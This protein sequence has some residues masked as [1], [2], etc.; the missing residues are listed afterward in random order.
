MALDFTNNSLTITKNGAS[1]A[2]FT[3]CNFTSYD[4]VLPQWGTATNGISGSSILL[5]AGQRAFEYTVPTDHQSLCTANLPA[6]DIADPSQYFD[7]VLDTGANILSSA[8]S[9]FSSGL[10]WIKDRD[11]SNQNQFVDSVRGNQAW[12]APSDVAQSTYSAPSGNSV[13]WCWSA[14]D[15]WSN[16]AGSNGADTASSGYRNLAR[17]FSIARFS[18]KRP[19]QSVFAH[20]LNTKPEFILTRDM[21]NE[22]GCVAYHVH[23]GTYYVEYFDGYFGG[24]SSGDYRNVTSSIIDMGNTSTGNEVGT[25]NMMCYSWAPI[26]GYS[27]F[28]SYT[29]N[30]SSDGAF[31]HTGFRVGWVVIK[32]RNTSGGVFGYDWNVIDVRRDTYNPSWQAL[33]SNQTYSEGSG[34]SSSKAIDVLSNGFKCRTSDKQFNENGRIYLYAAFAEH[35]FGG[36]GVSP[37]T[38][39]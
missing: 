13:A 32:G 26:P 2:T 7:T 3:N 36:D 34:T 19:T 29:G 28:G 11:N 24:S 18:G 22:R 16:S 10:W 21:D 38:A 33:W 8:Q 4:Y 35:P 6:P 39:R 20:G 17:G 12:T 1:Y 25:N 5:N 31:V 30:G 23:N 14:P 37:A 15:T 27:A 9:T